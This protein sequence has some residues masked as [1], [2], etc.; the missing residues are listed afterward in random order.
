MDLRK[1]VKPTEWTAQGKSRYEKAAIESHITTVVSDLYGIPKAEVLPVVQLYDWGTFY[2]PDGAKITK[3][4]QTI[5]RKFKTKEETLAK[6]PE[7]GR[8]VSDFYEPDSSYKVFF[9]DK[10]ILG[11]GILE[12]RKTCFAEGAMNA[13]NKHL[14]K[15]LRRVGML[16]IE[17]K[18][19]RGAARCL[20]YFA[21]SRNVFLFNFYYNGITQNKHL[22]IEAY[23]RIMKLSKVTWKECEHGG[24][25]LPVYR[26]TKSS[27]SSPTPAVHIYDA[28]AKFP[29]LSR[30]IPC[31]YC[32][33]EVVETDMYIRDSGSEKYGACS[34]LCF[35]KG[36]NRYVECSLCNEGLD[37][38][39]AFQY[40]DGMSA[41]FACVVCYYSKTS[42]CSRCDGRFATTKLVKDDAG[43]PICERCLRA[44]PACSVCGKR[45]A[46]S[47]YQTINGKV[48]CGECHINPKDICA[49]CHLT[50]TS[51]YPITVDGE[52]IRVCQ[53]CK[54]IYG[55]FDERGGVP[56]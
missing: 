37:K 19:G 39:G 36:S 35:L 47:N 27:P 49:V 55:Q 33:K 42:N 23:R 14:L 2:R 24:F 22:F 46:R 8:I 50:G 13:H 9:G 38:N 48:H 18:N 31:P 32:R 5:V 54:E 30:K 29:K 45:K 10:G 16:V 44:I 1:L 51:L 17:N 11:E 4:L 6:F 15:L 53:Y 34:R 3:S 12:G 26:N 25:F 41:K 56:A 7:M 28:R 21:G 40:T 43:A 20:C 52:K